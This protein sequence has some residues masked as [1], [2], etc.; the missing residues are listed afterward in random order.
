VIVE[1]ATVIRKD[2]T[3]SVFGREKGRKMFAAL[4]PAGEPD[5]SG[6]GYSRRRLEER[7]QMDRGVAEVSFSKL[8]T[9]TIVDRQEA[10]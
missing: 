9:S 5:P 4:T 7:P 8:K 3:E 2:G 6:V 10:A 1:H